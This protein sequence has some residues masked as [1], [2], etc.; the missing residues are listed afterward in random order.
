MVN[1]L[2]ACSESL[3]LEKD[4]GSSMHDHESEKK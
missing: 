4:K 1:F 2:I 3:P